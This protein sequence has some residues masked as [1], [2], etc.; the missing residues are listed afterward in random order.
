MF[1]KKTVGITNGDL[2]SQPSH[3]L[4]RLSGS[5]TLKLIVKAYTLFKTQY[6]ELLTLSCKNPLFEA[7]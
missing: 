5:G 4:E 2:L 6:P 1:W 3:S 7:K